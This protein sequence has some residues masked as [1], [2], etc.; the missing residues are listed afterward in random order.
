M[1]TFEEK[2]N[3]IKKKKENPPSYPDLI[4]CARKAVLQNMDDLIEE[5]HLYFGMKKRVYLQRFEVEF[6]IE[7][8]MKASKK[9]RK[10][11]EMEKE[12]IEKIESI[13]W[14]LKNQETGKKLFILM[15][16]GDDGS[17]SC[18]CSEVEE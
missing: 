12:V 5:Q 17:S 9:I 15:L 13:Q 10:I 3:Q 14:I 8:Q 4:Y 18:S 1:A 11:L 6:S 2:F 16:D 7:E